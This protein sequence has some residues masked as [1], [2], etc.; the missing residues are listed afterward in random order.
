MPGGHKC[1]ARPLTPPQE[2][3][4]NPEGGFQPKTPYQAVP[5]IAKIIMQAKNTQITQSDIRDL[6][7]LPEHTQ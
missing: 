7:G 6:F 2:L 4:Y 1:R 3:I 5:F